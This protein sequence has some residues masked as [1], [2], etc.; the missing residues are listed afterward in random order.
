MHRLSFL[1]R[2]GAGRRRGGTV[3]YQ[4]SSV[5]PRP[6]LRTFTLSRAPSSPDS[7]T[8]V[9]DRPKPQSTPDQSPTEVVVLQLCDRSGVRGSVVYQDRGSVTQW[10][11]RTGTRWHS[12]V[13]GKETG[14][15][16][17]C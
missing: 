1:S 14:S 16:V 6:S 13:P 5:G 10:C 15:T 8:R 11:A 12:G 2:A 7:S 9:S 4:E 3:D 17:V